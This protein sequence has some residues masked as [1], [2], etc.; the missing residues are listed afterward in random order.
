MRRYSFFLP[1]DLRRGLDTFH[2]RD[3]ILASEAI[4]RAIAEFLTRR[5]VSISSRPKGGQIRK[6]G[7]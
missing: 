1:D 2:A 4:R 3:G 7:K 6:R 5:Q